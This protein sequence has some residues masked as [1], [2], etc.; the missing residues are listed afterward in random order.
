MNPKPFS[1]LNHFT[2]PCDILLIYFLLRAERSL[3]QPVL[4]THHATVPAACGP[5]VRQRTFPCVRP[6]ITNVAISAPT[7]RFQ[8]RRPPPPRANL[9]AGP[10]EAN[11]VV[12]ALRGDDG[13]RRHLARVR[14][15]EMDGDRS[16][17]VA[18]AGHAVDGV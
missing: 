14:R 11:E 13:V 1:P 16:V 18:Y 12:P 8:H 6:G 5:K 3:Q 15:D 10:I 9:R 4:A 2:L 17:V 7:G